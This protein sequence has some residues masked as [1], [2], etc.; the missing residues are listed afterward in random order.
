M[1]LPPFTLKRNPR[2]RGIRIRIGQDGSC[3]VT[4]PRRVSLRLI[5][6]LVLEKVGWIEDA[7]ARV[8]SRPV[9]PLSGGTKADYARLKEQALRLAH[10]RLAF[11]N[12]VYKFS[13]TKVAIRNQTT[14][15]G[16]CTSSGTLSFNYRIV[17]LSPEAVDYIIVHELCHLGQMNHSAKFW[18][19]VAKAVPEH[20]RIRKEIC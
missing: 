17:H 7:I 18:A 10:A 2:S 12:D 13:Y 15:W 16:S 11:F 19:L 1:P 20:R 14:R 4:A 6:R 3:T 9:N 5:N 8:I